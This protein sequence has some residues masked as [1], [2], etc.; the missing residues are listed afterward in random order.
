MPRDTLSLATSPDAPPPTP[1]KG[2][3]GRYRSDAGLIRVVPAT[4]CDT[5]A[6][7]SVAGR[8]QSILSRLLGFYIASWVI[9]LWTVL[10]FSLGSAAMMLAIVIDLKSRGIL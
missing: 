1:L 7:P 9:L 3:V 10:S 6:T 5:I 4:P 8:L 2:G